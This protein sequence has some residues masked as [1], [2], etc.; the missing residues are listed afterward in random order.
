MDSGTDSV[1]VDVMEAK[2]REFRGK[3][4]ILTGAS[5]GIGVPIARELARYG[6][7]LALAAR[8][9]SAG[10]LEAVARDLA[11]MGIRAV[12]IPTDVTSPNDRQALVERAESEL[13]SVDLLVNNAGVEIGGAL[14]EM[15]PVAIRTM[16]ET[17]LVACI[18]MARL[19]LPGMLAR[20]S[21]HIVN[22]ASI[23]GKAPYPYNSIYTATKSGI[24][25]WSMALYLE[26]DGTGV[27]TSVICPGYVSGVGMFVN[28]GG[29]RPPMTGTVTPERVAKA[30][31]DA[32]YRD[33]PEVLV[34]PSVIRPLLALQQLAP[35]FASFYYKR[36]G[37]L[38]SLRRSAKQSQ[39]D[40]Q[41][42]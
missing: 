30:V 38:A 25:A 33:L 11:E 32:V 37:I 28:K 24:V 6:V 15:D 34:W 42:R 39:K 23:A 8:A 41:P 13:G 12:P 3:N 5:R 10:Q 7:N 14:A 9:S 26:L 21:G 31:V 18:E 16:V 22:I 17:N 20:H 2:V 1:A 27:S 36:F 35:S 19:V 40:K 29:K 4:A